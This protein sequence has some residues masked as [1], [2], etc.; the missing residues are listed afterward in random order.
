M[1]RNLSNIFL[2]EL[3]YSLFFMPLL[4]LIFLF[5]LRAE[6]GGS[7]ETPKNITATVSGSQVT[8]TWTMNSYVGITGFKIKVKNMDVA[9]FEDT[10]TMSRTVTS[11]QT[12]K[13]LTVTGSGSYRFFVIALKGSD[14]SSEGESN[15]VTVISSGGTGK[16]VKPSSFSADSGIGK[17]TLRW[18]SVSGTS[19]YRVYFGSSGYIDFAGC[20]GTTITKTV[21]AGASFEKG[22]QVLANHKYTGLCV[23]ALPENSSQS[24]SDNSASATATAYHL[25]APSFTVSSSIPGQAAVKYK[26]DIGTFY[27]QPVGIKFYAGDKLVKTLTDVG[28]VSFSVPISYNGTSK[29]SAHFY[30]TGPGTPG[31]ATSKSVT[32]ARLKKARLAGTKLSKNAVS[33]RITA[34]PGAIG[35]QIFKGTKK[36]ATTKKANYIYKA[37][38]A[39]TGQYY[40]KAYITLAGKKYYG[41]R[42]ARAKLQPNVKK[43]AGSPKVKSYPYATCRFNIRKISLKGNTY[44]VTGYA[45]NNRIFK[46]KK[47]KKL[48]IKIMGMQNDKIK[49]VAKKTWKN[50]TINVPR[51]SKKKF[52]FK[53]K[54]K[55]N[56]DLLRYVSYSTSTLAE[57]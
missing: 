24:E 44:T 39:G 45:V 28:S 4:L 10:I 37:K 32:S 54:G 18:S 8:L 17:I 11:G 52:T 50:K 46:C 49:V 35:Y 34:V 36:V 38:G 40:A 3:S 25:Y 15:E 43:W 14:E 12:Q 56:V 6:A 19:S 53:L 13:I 41:A 47:Y 29:I 16:L 1:K 42:S 51:E 9:G 30:L 48:T 55:V 7:V 31:S 57:W 2:K 26:G 20:S 33:L 22:G 27:D 21:A 5:P 23:A